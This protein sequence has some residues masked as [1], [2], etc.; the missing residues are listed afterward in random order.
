M[1]HSRVSTSLLQRRLHV[2]YPRAARLI[3]MLEEEGVV[4]AAESGQSRQV[5]VADRPDDDPFD[6]E[7]DYGG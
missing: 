1:E 7:D 4:S 2:G 5:L 3:D 6:E